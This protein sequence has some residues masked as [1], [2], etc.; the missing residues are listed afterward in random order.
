MGGSEKNKVVAA[1]LAFFLGGF[2]VHKFYL[3]Y[4]TAGF[5]MLGVWV[6][7]FMLTFVLIGIFPL[8][9]LGV[10]AF[11]EAIIYIITPDDEF[12]RKYVDNQRPWF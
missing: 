2:G 11:I 8:M 10:V 12:Q 1:L 5:I 3:G 7:S 6:V 9:I 4:N